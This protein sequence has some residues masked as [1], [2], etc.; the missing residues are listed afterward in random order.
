MK[1]LLLLSVLLLSSC[2]TTGKIAAADDILEFAQGLQNNDSVRIERHLD[3]EALKRQANFIARDVALEQIS[4]EM[5]NDLKAKLAAIAFANLAKP[6][7]D[8][9]TDEALSSDNLSYF[10]QKAGLTQN[11][12]LPSRFKTSLAIQYISETKVCI[13]DDKTKQ[14]ILYFGQYPDAWKLYAIDENALRARLKSKNYSIK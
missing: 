7:V 14:C 11:L 8:M 4:K 10:A 1:K 3:R 2:A 12:K 5:G 9:I 6:I 13:P